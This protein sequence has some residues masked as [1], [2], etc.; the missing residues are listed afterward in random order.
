[1]KNILRFS[2]M[3]A[4]CLMIMG[5]PVDPEC[6]EGSQSKEDCSSFENGCVCIE[7]VVLNGEVWTRGTGQ[8]DI[9]FPIDS[10]NMNTIRV[11]ISNYDP[12]LGEDRLRL[13]AD[14]N[15]D[16]QIGS[17]EVFFSQEPDQNGIVEANF[18]VP[19]GVALLQDGRL[20]LDRDGTGVIIPPRPLC[21]VGP[22]CYIQIGNDGN[23]RKCD[24]SLIHWEEFA[25]A[26][27]CF[28]K[29]DAGEL[30][31]SVGMV[32]HPDLVTPGM[33]VNVQINS[34]KYIDTNTEL[35]TSSLLENIT[36]EGVP[37]GGL[38]YAE[39]FINFSV[40][41]DIS[42][43]PGSYEISVSVLSAG[44]CDG[45]NTNTIPFVLEDCPECG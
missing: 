41:V 39:G 43:G 28:Y 2:V 25:D 11:N 42:I 32:F 30:P 10:R 15:G 14:L 33:S 29:N 4:A 36:I 21:I 37:V 1:M 12:L 17:D 23:P 24:A 8:S 7:E 34:L 27:D 13:L 16:G 3:I 44:I 5:C 20:E 6:E 19:P 38:Y 35:L 40:P 45:N 31:I 9:L 18:H 26:K 22:R